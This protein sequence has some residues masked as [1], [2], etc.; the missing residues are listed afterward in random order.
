MF[1]NLDIKV[2]QISWEFYYHMRRLF[3]G[4]LVQILKVVPNE[5]HEVIKIILIHG[6]YSVSDHDPTH[7]LGVSSQLEHAGKDQSFFF[8]A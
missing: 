1:E 5:K 6:C 4:N 7:P 8:L 2:S 3:A